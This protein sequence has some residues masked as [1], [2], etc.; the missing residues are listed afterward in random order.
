[1]LWFCIIIAG[2][3]FSLF[4]HYHCHIVFVFF[5]NHHRFE[6]E[7]SYIYHSIICFLKISTDIFLLFT[8]DSNILQHPQS[9]TDFLFIYLFLPALE[10]MK[11]SPVTF[12]GIVFSVLT[13]SL[14]SVLLILSTLLRKYNGWECFRS[15]LIVL[16]KRWS[17]LICKA[18]GRTA[19]TIF[20]REQASHFG[21]PVSV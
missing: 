2:W 15:L 3:G 5:Y 12:T 1:M 18:A 17:E 9:L 10:K 13:D 16:T 19:D 11:W 6:A 8:Y 21:I 20:L 7:L 4:F 14:S